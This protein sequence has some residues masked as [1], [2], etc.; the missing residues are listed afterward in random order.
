MYS[1]DPAPFFLL[2]VQTI[3]AIFFRHVLLLPLTLAWLLLHPMRARPP[4]AMTT[5]PNLRLRQPPTGAPARRKQV[6]SRAALLRARRRRRTDRWTLSPREVRPRQ[7]HRSSLRAR[8]VLDR[9]TLS[10]LLWTT[11]HRLSS[12][13]AQRCVALVPL[14]VVMIVFI[15]CRCRSLVC[16]ARMCVRSHLDDIHTVLS[17]AVRP[18]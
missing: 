5:A 6:A 1:R 14:G 12:H 10:R 16:H 15:C 17:I 11:T 2:Q 13:A 4:T 8:R 9:Q 18:C 3:F 7:P